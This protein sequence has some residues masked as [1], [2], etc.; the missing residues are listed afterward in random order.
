[1]MTEKTYTSDLVLKAYLNELTS[2]F[3]DDYML[4]VEI[5]DEPLDIAA[6]SRAVSTRSGKY[7]PA[8]I[9]GLLQLSIDVIVEA[10]ST[11]HT[12]NTPLSNIRP[13]ATGTVAEADLS[14]PVDRSKVRVRFGF[15]QGAQARQ[16]MEDVHL[17]LNAKPA[18]TGPYIAGITS[19]DAPNPDTG[20]PATLRA[21]RMAKLNVR[22][23]KL[24]GEGAGITFT[25]VAN[26]AKT[27]F[28]PAN[29]V[30]P[31]TPTRLQCILPPDMTDGEWLVKIETRA[32]GSGGAKSAVKTLRSFEL[33]RPFVIAT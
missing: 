9:A 20:A 32:S 12:V 28:I 27:F 33:V 16:A 19:A 10:V 13:I 5:Q 6:I 14:K 4:R 29:E 31:N 23:G 24:V 21:G 25:S 22:N 30:N 1:M 15:T 8:E 7:E 3:P 26:P 2:H 18:L 11:G 17:V